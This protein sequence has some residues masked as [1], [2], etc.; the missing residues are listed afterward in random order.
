MNPLSVDATALLLLVALI[1]IVLSFVH[2]VPPKRR[3][4]LFPV[5]VLI[6]AATLAYNAAAVA[7]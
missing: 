2:A 4:L 6:L 5:G 1:F 7:W 3:D